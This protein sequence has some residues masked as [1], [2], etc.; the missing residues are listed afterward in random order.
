MWAT[1]HVWCNLCGHDWQAVYW[2]VS[3][4]LQC[5]ECR[6]M[7]RVNVVSEV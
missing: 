5:P 7:S 6:G 1:Q 3:T 2:T 4:R